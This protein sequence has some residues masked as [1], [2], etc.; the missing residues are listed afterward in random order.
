MECVGRLRPP[1]ARNLLGVPGF[2]ILDVDEDEEDFIAIRPKRSPLPRRKSSI[3]D[4]DLEADVPLCGS[5][6]VSFADAK[7]LNLVE[8][9]EFDTWEVPKLP[10]QDAPGATGIDGEEYYLSP[11]TFSLMLSSEE[12][13]AKVLQQKIELETIDFLPGTTILKGVIRVLNVSYSKAVFIRTTLDQWATHFDLLAEYIPGSSD[14]GTDCFS[15][16]LTL[17]PWFREQGARVEF[18]LRYETPEGTFWANNNGKN[19]VLL[20]HRR[21]RE[22][23][24]TQ[25]KEN[26]SVKSCLKN[27]SQSLSTVENISSK[28][29][30]SQDTATSEKSSLKL[31]RRKASNKSD[32]KVGPSAEEKQK[33]LMEDRQNRTQRRRRKA[34]R[35]DQ[36][37]NYFAQRNDTDDT[38]GHKAHP[39][40]KQEPREGKFVFEDFGTLG[41]AVLN[42][43]QGFVT[44][45]E[46]ESSKRPSS[47]G[48]QKSTLHPPKDPATEKQIIRSCQDQ[49]SSRES[50]TFTTVVA[51]LYQ[52]VFGRLDADIPSAADVEKQ[53]KTRVDL[54][55]KMPIVCKQ[56]V[57]SREQDCI[58]AVQ[59]SAQSEQT[60]S[61]RPALADMLEGLDGVCGS[62]DSDL[63]SSQTKTR[64]KDSD[65]LRGEAQEDDLTRDLSRASDG[66]LPAER[67][68][69]HVAVNVA[70]RN[71]KIETRADP[72]SLLRE[73]GRSGDDADQQSSCDPAEVT[74][75][76]DS[77]KIKNKTSTFV[78]KEERLAAENDLESENRDQAVVKTNTNSLIS[79]PET[80]LNNLNIIETES[81]SKDETQ[82]S[83]VINIIS[84][85]A[86]SMENQENND[87]IGMDAFRETLEEKDHNGM[88]DISKNDGTFCLAE[89]KMVKNWEMMVEEEESNILT[90]EKLIDL[91]AEDCRGMKTD[92]IEVFLEELIAAEIQAQND[93]AAW[94]PNEECTDSEPVQVVITEHFVGEKIA[95]EKD[96]VFDEP[97]NQSEEE[98]KETEQNRES[99]G[100][101]EWEGEEKLEN[102][103]KEEKSS[104]CTPESL[105][106][107]SGEI[108]NMDANTKSR[109]EVK[110]PDVIGD[111]EEEGL[112]E[113]ECPQSDD[114]K[115]GFHCAKDFRQ[116]CPSEE[117]STLASER[118]RDLASQDSSSAE[119]DSDDE[120]ELYMY[121]LRVAGAT[122]QAG[123]DKVKEAGFP[124]GKRPSASRAR[125]PSPILPP[126][127]ESVDEE[128][129]VSRT[130]EN[131]TPE[132]NC[133]KV[134]WWMS[135]SSISKSLFYVT[136]LVVFLAVANRYDFL[137]CFGLYLMSVVWLWCQGEKQVSQSNK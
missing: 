22:D 61:P 132:D 93:E 89:M 70:D 121:R 11:L 80:V 127:C 115:D 3:T 82:H 26:L 4:E 130:Q 131:P 91:N 77:A 57:D 110:D 76:N 12:V 123:K 62:F 10:G 40:T 39:E 126:I 104:D 111:M 103:N 27:I 96:L 2:N 100:G 97:V 94:E 18:C 47:G 59:S 43:E 116:S 105:A 15:F 81:S 106:D 69:L 113:N 120:V 42:G 137:A 16:R 29:A 54:S 25:Q 30:P 134:T 14:G 86:G 53:T 7:G 122:A 67:A 64:D 71:A 133:Q 31:D 1:Q 20:C 34:E 23:T 109:E 92:K 84:E 102:I 117:T 73:S 135:W 107:Y 101:L 45:K 37:R 72:K 85:V 129:H 63:L 95:E 8:V 24:D 50:F 125:P 58:D 83:V 9:K 119:S 98:M 55:E 5:R 48:D 74:Q 36:V 128:Q 79:R 99:E 41:G 118:S 124:P 66:P 44:N 114:K 112:S 17:V 65:G 108:E 78:T 13:F 33:L 90:N 75:N 21:I 52:Q 51:P 32:G 19:Y 49:E 28:Q 46:V 60:Q 38:D 68:C 56:T 35:M 87:S 88:K 136:L 6:R